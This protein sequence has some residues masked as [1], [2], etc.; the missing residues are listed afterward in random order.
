[1]NLTNNIFTIIVTYNGIEWLQKC[2]ESLKKSTVKT[3]VVIVDNASTDGTISLIKSQYPTIN[4]IE[5]YEN[6]GF[7]KANNIGI[8]KALDLGANAVFLLN[9]DTTIEIDCLEHLL[10]ISKTN[11]DYGILS[12]LHFNYEGGSLEYYF[13]Q[14][15]SKNDLLTKD[16]KFGKFP[17]SIYELPFVNA[18]AWFIP[19]STFEIIGGFDLIFHHYGEDNNYCQRLNYH[20]LKIGVAP[21]AKIYHDSKKRSGLPLPLFSKKYYEME[22]KQLQIR[23]ADINRGFNATDI[24]YIRKHNV[25]LILRNILKLNFKN[26]G[27]YIKKYLIFGKEFERILRSRE[28]NKTKGVHYLTLEN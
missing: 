19:K 8:S 9:Q 4:L 1:M 13:E 12:P 17:K 18:A 23:Y 10:E 20:H 2:I 25:K 3:E 16:V 6:V 7:G 11:A 5:Q 28:I 21:K 24:K 14:F 22:V 26:V 27:G 15:S